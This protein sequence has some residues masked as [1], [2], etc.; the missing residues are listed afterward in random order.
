MN[1]V[2]NTAESTFV[3]YEDKMSDFAAFLA[4]DTIDFSAVNKVGPGETNDP[5]K[6]RIGTA[7]GS[8]SV[9]RVLAIKSLS[10]L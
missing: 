5:E 8:V 1:E 6:S 10:T 7:S 3:L 2:D 9:F 4:A